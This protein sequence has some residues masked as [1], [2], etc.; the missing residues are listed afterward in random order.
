MS[1]VENLLAHVP[2]VTMPTHGRVLLGHRGV[3]GDVAVEEVVGE[4]AQQVGYGTRQ[5]VQV[6]EDRLAQVDMRAGRPRVRSGGEQAYPDQAGRGRREELGPRQGFFRRLSVRRPHSRS[7][8]PRRTLRMV[9]ATSSTVA[10]TS[11]WTT[12]NTASSAASC[13]TATPSTMVVRSAPLGPVASPPYV[14]KKF[15]PIAMAA[16]PWAMVPRPARGGAPTSESAT[17]PERTATHLAAARAA[18]SS[19]TAIRTHGVGSVSSAP[20]NTRKIA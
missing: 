4:C 12:S 19:G 8:M 1:Q 6:R 20:A 18:T 17:L 15:R 2:G 10:S 7:E 14:M 16:P 3:G 11:S 13:A 5:L 9:A